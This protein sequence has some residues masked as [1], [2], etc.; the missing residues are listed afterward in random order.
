LVVEDRKTKREIVDFR[1]FPA[2]GMI[3]HFTKDTYLERVF[4]DL[5]N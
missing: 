2:A 5:Y 3:G 1:K 4:K